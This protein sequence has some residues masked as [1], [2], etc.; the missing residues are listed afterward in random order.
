MSKIVGWGS[1]QKYINCFDQGFKCFCKS[2]FTWNKNDKPK[3]HFFIINTK[4]P[5]YLSMSFVCDAYMHNILWT[6]CLDCS[7]IVIIHNK[8]CMRFSNQLGNGQKVLGLHAWPT[9]QGLKY[10]L[11][12]HNASW[13]GCWL[14]HTFN[15]SGKKHLSKISTLSN[16]FENHH[17]EPLSCR[18]DIWW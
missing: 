1:S 5:I 11:L 15:T 2:F 4:F 6:L 14:L 18:T 7:I 12:G 17:A 8:S 10:K 13:G 9:S 3:P 16:A